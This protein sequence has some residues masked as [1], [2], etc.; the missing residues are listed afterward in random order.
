M[1]KT[2]IGY[3]KNIITPPLG[4]QLA[5]HAI[6]DR[7]AE[8]IH[9]ELYCRVII[10]DNN[11]EE[12]C[13]I[14]ND[15]VGLGYDF[16]DETKVNLKELGLKEENIFIGCT[17]T[18]SGPKGLTK[19][20][21]GRPEDI[22]MMSGHY[23]ETLCQNIQQAIITT[24]KEALANKT[25]GVLNYGISEV[26]GV[27]S[28]RNDRNNPGDQI[29]LALEFILDNGKKILAY[30]YSCHPT[31]VNHRNHFITADFPHGVA[32]LIEDTEYELVMFINGSSGDISTR[33]TRREASFEEIDRLGLILKNKID[34]ALE[35]TTTS[36]LENIKVKDKTF[37]IAL[38]RIGTVEEIQAKLDNYQKELDLA[39]QESKP[40]IRTYESFVEGARINLFLA[41]S[42]QEGEYLDIKYKLLKI[43]DL[44]FVFVPSELFYELVKPL[45]E[46]SNGK[47]FFCTHFNG[48]MGYIA[49]QGS[50]DRDT[51]ETQTSRFLAGQGEVFREEVKKEVEA[52]K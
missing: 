11:G 28:N 3:A 44:I 27:S 23:N 19:N 14:Q 38:K 4:T 26:N 33:F 36:D 15:L 18:H 47:L 43:D 52:F 39:I 37:K 1:E 24:V 7:K 40:N 21:K 46:E 16:V 8:G 13:I 48:S 50:Y 2:K 45:K 34:E 35:T 10:L 20:V 31:V 22:E 29:L 17:H 12:F 49:D 5:G 25:P 9:D 32:K 51:Y 6:M 41:Q 30:N 42:G